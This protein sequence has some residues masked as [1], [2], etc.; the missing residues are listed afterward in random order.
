[1]EMFH[2]FCVQKSQ[3]LGLGLRCSIEVSKLLIILKS[4]VVF[5]MNINKLNR[6]SETVSIAYDKSAYSLKVLTAGGARIMYFMYIIKIMIFLQLNEYFWADSFR[7]IPIVDMMFWSDSKIFIFFS[8]DWIQTFEY[9]FIFQHK[10]N[11]KREQN[12]DNYKRL[13]NNYKLFERNLSFNAFKRG[14]LEFLR[15]VFTNV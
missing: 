2:Y 8:Y 6:T 10:R 1:M 3:I 9:K 7:R 4:S 5:R 12:L 15:S 13:K 11:L 14:A